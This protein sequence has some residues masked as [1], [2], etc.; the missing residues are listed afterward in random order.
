MYT[1]AVCD[2][3]GAQ[4][5]YL[6]ELVEAW[7]EKNHCLA[8]VRQYPEAESF[9]FEYE[10]KRL[11]RLYMEMKGNYLCIALTNTA[12]GGPFTSFFSFF[13]FGGIKRV[14]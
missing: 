8:E 12:G 4:R 3:D 13:A 9:L 6:A 5:R 14:I 2:D 10:E 11:I 1:F 7:A